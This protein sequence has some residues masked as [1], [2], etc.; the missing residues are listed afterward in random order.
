LKPLCNSA[1]WY[2][3]A[4]IAEQFPVAGIQFAY[5][6]VRGTD[7]ME[8][9]LVDTPAVRPV[10]PRTGSPRCRSHRRTTVRLI[11][12]TAILAL[13]ALPALAEQFEVDD[14]ACADGRKYDLKFDMQ[15][16]LKRKNLD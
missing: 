6:P 12:S 1:F 10:T 5:V 8:A 2:A 4:E 9:G 14:A 3:L 15:M 13:S 11:T 7:G 16:K